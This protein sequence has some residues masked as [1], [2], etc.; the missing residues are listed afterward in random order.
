M[1]SRRMVRTGMEFAGRSV[2]LEFV[3][4]MVAFTMQVVSKEKFNE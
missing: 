4:N 3:Y 2:Y 1:A